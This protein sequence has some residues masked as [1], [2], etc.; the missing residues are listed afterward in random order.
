[1]FCSSWKWWRMFW[2]L[3]TILK[4]PPWKLTE[5]H[6][7]PTPVKSLKPNWQEYIYHLVGQWS[8]IQIQY[9]FN[10]NV[11]YD[12]IVCSPYAY[13]A[14]VLYVNVSKCIVDFPETGNFRS[15]DLHYYPHKI[16]CR[17][18]PSY[19]APPMS[20]STLLLT[21]FDHNI[22]IVVPLK[23]PQKK[24]DTRLLQV[25]QLL[26]FII[27]MYVIMLA[28]TVSYLLYICM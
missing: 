28:T 3:E 17:F 19:D 20:S 2:I 16:V 26:L 25:C 23:P 24:V 13:L 15:E 7:V 22:E 27:R 8:L 12:I 11:W 9:G 14:L 10:N 1:M 18:H 6:M 21:G 5:P 4:C